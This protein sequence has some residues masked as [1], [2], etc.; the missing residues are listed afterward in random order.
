MLYLVLKTPPCDAYVLPHWWAKSM[1][2]FLVFRLHS[3]WPGSCA[4][5]T[6]C[7]QVCP[8][9]ENFIFIFSCVPFWFITTFIPSKLKML[10][11]HSHYLDRVPCLPGSLCSISTDSS[12]LLMKQLYTTCDPVWMLLINR[13]KS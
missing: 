13:S 6:E 4:A 8:V 1:F 11:G 9:E 5:F 10:T 7:D 3:N 12:R 2:F